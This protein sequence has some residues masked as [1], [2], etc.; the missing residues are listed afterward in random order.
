MS[1]MERLKRNKTKLIEVLCSDHPFILNKVQERK[2]ITSRE[3]NN[4]KSINKAHAE[5]HVIE[6]VD[7]LMNKGEETCQNFLKLLET[8]DVAE[9]YPDLKS[10]NLHDV[11]LQPVQVT[12]PCSADMVPETKRLKKDEVY[13]LKSEP[14]GLCLIINNEN[15]HS[16]NQ[17][18]GTNKDAERLAK[19]FRWLGF[20]V[21]MCNDQTGDQMEQTLK[22]VASPHNEE[23]QLQLPELGVQEWCDGCLSAPQQPVRHGDAF[24][25]CILSHGSLGKVFG[26]DSQPL[27]IKEIKRLFVASKLPVLAGKPKVFLIQACQNEKPLAIQRGVLLKEVEEDSATSIPEEA[28]FLVAVST[29]EDYVSFRDPTCGSW[30]IQSVCDQLELHC[31]RGED[32]NSILLRVNEAVGQKEGSKYNTGRAKQAPEVKFTLRKK[33]VLMPRCT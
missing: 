15:F 13:E 18:R 28:D 25:C 4:L 12:S 29:V 19:V 9:T 14:V 3:Y 16:L 17:R 5:D 27:V 21:L 22:V 7:K 20:K 10:I 24:V 32:F 31:P 11:L 6:L 1:A 26:V 8:D 2:L 33:L 23:M 30:F